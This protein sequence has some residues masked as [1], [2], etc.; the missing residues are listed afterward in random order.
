MLD[1]ALSGPL[2][3][4]SMNLMISSVS[5]DCIGSLDKLPPFMAILFVVI[6]FFLYWISIDKWVQPHENN[7]PYYST[8]VLQ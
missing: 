3:E 2:I 5:I 8:T 1:F 6:W 4:L 7:S